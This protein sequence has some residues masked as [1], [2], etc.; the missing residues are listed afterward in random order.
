MIGWCLLVSA[1]VFAS[2]IDAE[3]DGF[4]Y[5]MECESSDARVWVVPASDMALINAY[6]DKTAEPGLWLGAFFPTDPPN[7]FL[8]EEIAMYPELWGALVRR[9]FQHLRDWVAHDCV[10]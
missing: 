3:L 2:T 5:H 6:V 10:G 7:I 4:T 9:E 8:T 1:L